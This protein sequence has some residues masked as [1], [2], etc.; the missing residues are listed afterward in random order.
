MDSSIWIEY[1]RRRPGP[2]VARFDALVESNVPFAITPVILQEILQGARSATEFH[3]L[4]E[5]LLSQRLI[6]PLE[7][8][9]SYAS[10]AEIYFRCRRAGITPRSSTDCLIAQIAIDNNAVLLHND[11]DFDRISKVVPELM[12]Y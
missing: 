3:A 12:I 9:A 10:A 5:N 11:T 8:I 4:S 6:Y 2:A 7:P 1:L